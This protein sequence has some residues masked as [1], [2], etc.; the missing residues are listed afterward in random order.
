MAVSVIPSGSLLTI[1][2]DAAANRVTITQNDVLN[3]LTVQTATSTFTFDSDDVETIDVDLFDGKDEFTYKLAAGS[4]FTHKKIIDLDLG[5]KDDKATLRFIG[6]STASPTVSTIKADLSMNLKGGSGLD[7]MLVVLG[8]IDDDVDLKMEG[9]N[10]ADI[11]KV[12]L[13]NHLLDDADV[14]LELLGGA[15]N[16]TIEVNAKL[17]HF[18]EFGQ[19]QNEI[20]ADIDEDACL[21]VI[22]KG[23]ANNDRMDFYYQGLM[24]GDLDVE[25]QGETGNADVAKLIA[26]FEAGSDTDDFHQ[27]LWRK[28]RQSRSARLI[29]FQDLE[30]AHGRGPW[31][32]SVMAPGGG[33]SRAERLTAVRGPA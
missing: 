29:N 6:A 32:G 3:K 7:N 14:T 25:I 10:D 23:G 9:G 8:K 19:F 31:A 22:M 26:V 18:N 24:Q 12:Q 15:G 33:T 30:R 17:G 27:E 28:R 1:T 11:L 20:G 2:G 16:D 4:D 5:L 13:R 21:D